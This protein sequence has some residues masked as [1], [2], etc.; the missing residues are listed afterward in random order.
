MKSILSRFVVVLILSLTACTAPHS[1][2]TGGYSSPSAPSGTSVSGAA[3]VRGDCVIVMPIPDAMEDSD[4]PVPGTGERLG[5][6]ILQSVSQLGL[7]FEEPLLP[8]E[9]A[10]CPT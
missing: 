2:T 6:L 5:G 8:I 10:L 3:F 7:E 4:S 1:Q 9:L